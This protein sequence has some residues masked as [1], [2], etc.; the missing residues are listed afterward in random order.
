MLEKGYY[1][2]Y[3]SPLFDGQQKSEPKWAVAKR[4]YAIAMKLA[5]DPD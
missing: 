1:L 5:E 2:E 4:D 3:K